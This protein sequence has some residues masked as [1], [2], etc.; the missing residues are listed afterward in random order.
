[1]PTSSVRKARDLQGYF[2]NKNFNLIYLFI[3]F[4]FFIF[5]LDKCSSRANPR[6]LAITHQMRR[7]K[8]PP[9]PWRAGFVTEMHICI[10]LYAS[11]NLNSGFD[12]EGGGL[13]AG[14][15]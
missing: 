10:D 4:Y 2:F 6:A 15:K 3:L 13:V 5:F 7:G 1:M 12:L 9:H 14:L 8:L 11:S